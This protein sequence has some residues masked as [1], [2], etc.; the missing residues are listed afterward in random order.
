MWLATLLLMPLGLSAGGPGSPTTDERTLPEVFGSWIPKPYDHPPTF[1][2]GEPYFDMV[3]I[4]LGN[5]KH[6]Q[7]K[8]P[9]RD[10]PAYLEP[11]PEPKRQDMKHSTPLPSCRGGGGETSKLTT[12]QRCAVCESFARFLVGSEAATIAA[13]NPDLE[14]RTNVVSLVMDCDKGFKRE[15]VSSMTLGRVPVGNASTECKKFRDEFSAEY[16]GTAID[17]WIEDVGDKVLR[18]ASTYTAD[19]DVGEFRCY[20]H[21]TDAIAAN[22]CV[23]MECCPGPDCGVSDRGGPVYAVRKD[24]ARDGK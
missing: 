2:E 18:G 17:T 5:G 12:N 20:H 24:D 11:L 19:G 16:S 23:D 6:G 7:I 10:F 15:D 21:P 14:A 3:N 8:V 13:N 22:M 9:V 1:D 4:T